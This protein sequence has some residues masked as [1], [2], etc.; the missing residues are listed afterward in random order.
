MA[1]AA[2]GVGHR[3]RAAD[4]DVARPAHVAGNQDRLADAA[5]AGRQFLVARRKGPR[6]ALAM[7]AERLGHA[8]HLIGLD[9][10]DVVGHVVDQVHAQSLG[11]QLKDLGESLAGQVRHD[12]TIAP[13]VVGGRPHGPQIL[14]ALRRFDRGA[15]EL[16][17]GQV[18]AVFSR[19]VAKILEGVVADLI[20]QPA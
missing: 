6:R 1:T 11:R 20:A 8:V 16:L 10:G 7:Y 9:L 15:G 5:I 12:L 14:L 4:Q 13:G 3:A 18:D 19:H 17:V 2:E